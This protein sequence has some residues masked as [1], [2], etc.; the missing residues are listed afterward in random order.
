MVVIGFEWF[1]N[2]CYWFW[3]VFERLLL[4]VIGSLLPQKKYSKSHK[5]LD[6]SK[7]KR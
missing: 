4:V 5:R 1:L 6:K 2:G 3:M 7:K